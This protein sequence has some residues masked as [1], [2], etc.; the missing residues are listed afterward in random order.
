MLL[1]WNSDTVSRKK[2]TGQLFAQQAIKIKF[3]AKEGFSE[4]CE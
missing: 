3:N 4:V 1:L 2:F